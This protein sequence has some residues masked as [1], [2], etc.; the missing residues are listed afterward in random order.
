MDLKSKAIQSLQGAITLSEAFEKCKNL[1]PRIDSIF[2][3][4]PNSCG[5][6]FGPSKAGK[7]IYAECALLSISAGRDHFFNSPLVAT[8]RKCLYVSFEEDFVARCDRNK[9]QLKQ[10]SK[11]EQESIM[12]NYM[13]SDDKLPAYLYEDDWDELELMIAMHQ[14]KFVC[15]DSI[16]RLTMRKITD[17]DTAKELCFKIR[18][19]V[20]RYQFTCFLINHTPKG[21]NVNGLDIHS[22]SGSRIFA[23]E[24]DFL[25]G[26]NVTSQ[27][28]RYVKNVALRYRPGEYDKVRCFKINENVFTECTGSDYE[29]KLVSSA[30]RRKNVENRSVVLNGIHDYIVESGRTDFGPSNFK[31]LHETGPGYKMARSTVYDC[32]KKLE[33]ENVIRSV[34]NDNYELV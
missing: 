6:I 19:L 2:G 4:P 34:G 23:Q 11:Q 16:S 9:L 13:I 32:F 30:D 15:I 8:E 24:S 1:P 3:V 14:P 29:E 28:V 12:A 31:H 5:Q 25:I 33:S 26:I 21:G 10:F 22:L 18:D 20:K 17:E 27:G 7:T